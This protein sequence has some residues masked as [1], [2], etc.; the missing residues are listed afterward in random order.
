[1]LP[2]ARQGPSW[3]GGAGGQQASADPRNGIA[4]GSAPRRFPFLPVQAGTATAGSRHLRRSQRPQLSG[5]T[6]TPTL[7]I[8]RFADD[9]EFVPFTVLAA[10]AE[11]HCKRPL[12]EASMDMSP[13]PSELSIN[14]R[15]DS[16]P[17]KTGKS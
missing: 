8:A 16:M 1:V 6:V 14:P 7:K 9:R 12:Q 13:S 2:G 15:G 11:R 17:S 10:V 5:N 4:F 3:R